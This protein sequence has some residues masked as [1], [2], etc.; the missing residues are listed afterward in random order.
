MAFMLS[1]LFLRHT[2]FH[3]R[4]KLDTPAMWIMKTDVVAFRQPPWTQKPNSLAV[5]P[6]N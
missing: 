3:W 5:W 2:C 6:S 1:S 4:A